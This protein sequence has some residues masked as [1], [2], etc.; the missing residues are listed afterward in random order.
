MPNGSRKSHR[1]ATPTELLR[2]ISGFSEISGDVENPSARLYVLQIL[3]RVFACF[4][5]EFSTSYDKSFAD[6]EGEVS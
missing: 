6:D 4:G 2:D 3:F 1:T 5:A